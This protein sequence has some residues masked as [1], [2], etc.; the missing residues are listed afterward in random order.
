MWLC[1]APRL[2]TSARELIENYITMTIAIG[3]VSIVLRDLTSLPGSKTF[4]QG[5]FPDIVI[6]NVAFS[7]PDLTSMQRHSCCVG[8]RSCPDKL[9]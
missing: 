6:M 2:L 1:K 7:L 5:H 9:F 4:F 3:V 8:M